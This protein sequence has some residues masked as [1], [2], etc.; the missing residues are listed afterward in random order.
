MMRRL[1]LYIHIPFCK[2]KCRYCD[3]LSFPAKEAMIPQYVKGLCREIRSL[4]KN[5]EGFS[6]AAHTIETVYIGGGT[7][8]LLSGEEVREL[9]RTVRECF[10]LS[11]TAEITMEVNPGTVTKE[12]LEAYFEAGVNRLSIGLQSAN[13]N[14][15]KRLG[16][17]HDYARFLECFQLARKAGFQNINVDVMTA[18]PGQTMES[19][20]KTLAKVISL[21][22]EHISAY[23]LILEEG[24]VLYEEF[25]GNPDLVMEKETERSMYE[26]V[27]NLLSENGY[28]QYEISNFAKPGYESRH[29]SAYWNRT[30]YLGVGLGA[31]GLLSNVRYR[32]ETD[33]EKYLMC[34]NPVREKQPLSIPEQMEEFLFLGLRMRKG[35]S[36]SDFFSCFHKELHEV[37][38]ETIKK[39]KKQKLILENEE[40]ICLTDRGID[41][42]NYVFSEFLLSEI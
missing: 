4:E 40:M 27:R 10:L 9:L 2:K 16:R 25:K 26:L 36:K 20:K 6:Y 15:L 42:G 41:Y 28:E 32:N 31:S 38:G 18:L 5:Y 11:K 35:V 21:K 24:T 37:Y 1:G 17:I 8:S 39:L 22:A 13:D 33:F 19:L 3:F 30:E 14:E 29:N 23:S 12:K 7:P 34:D